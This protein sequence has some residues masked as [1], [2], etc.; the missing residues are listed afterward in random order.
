MYKAKQN[1]EF[2]CSHFLKATNTFWLFVCLF[3]CLSIYGHRDRHLFL[4]CKYLQGNEFPPNWQQLPRT[5]TSIREKINVWGEKKI[6]HTIFYSTMSRLPP[7]RVNYHV[8]QELA[9][10]LAPFS[11][12]FSFKRFGVLRLSRTTPYL[13]FSI[14]TIPRSILISLQ[15]N[16]V[17][18]MFIFGVVHLWSSAA[19]FW[20]RAC[21]EQWDWQHATATPLKQTT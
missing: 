17:T 21:A 20:Y 19:G 11:T 6:S 18:Y 14:R 15:P 3:M 13:A 8:W 9:C 1:Q 4:E 2:L 12:T 16:K 7:L 5:N 10:L